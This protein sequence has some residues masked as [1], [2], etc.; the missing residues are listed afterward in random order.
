MTLL[1]ECCPLQHLG[2]EPEL[3]GETGTLPGDFAS[4]WSDSVLEYLQSN[5]SC[6][7]AG[8]VSVLPNALQAAPI[9]VFTAHT[10]ELF[11]RSLGTSVCC[12]TSAR[13]PSTCMPILAASTSSSH[14]PTPSSSLTFSSF[15][16]SRT[17]YARRGR[18]SSADAE[19]GHFPSQN[20]RL[21]TSVRVGVVA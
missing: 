20:S 3:T 12:Y 9:L 2:G 21:S 6:D 1:F 16:T 7:D 13:F 15:T 19:T 14:T 18:P 17:S 4:K 10:P 11:A 8:A 5:P